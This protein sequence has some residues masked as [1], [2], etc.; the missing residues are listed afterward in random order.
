MIIRPISTGCFF[1]LVLRLVLFR[2]CLSGGRNSFDLLPAI[3]K[4]PSQVKVLSGILGAFYAN[5]FVSPGHLRKGYRSS[6]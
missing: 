2:S 3:V 6:L 1:G 4:M 5:I